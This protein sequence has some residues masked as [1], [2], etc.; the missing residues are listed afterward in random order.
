MPVFA[1]D[2]SHLSKARLKLDLIAHNVALPPAKSK[3]EAYVELHTKH[4][5]TNNAANF[6]S[7]EEPEPDIDV[8]Y[9]TSWGLC[10]V[11]P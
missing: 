1:E 7:D 11:K 3:K 2:P 5:E 10:L 9:G 8:S 4:L 6:S